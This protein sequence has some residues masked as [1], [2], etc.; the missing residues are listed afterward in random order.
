MKI[1]LKQ[2]AAGILTVFALFGAVWGINEQYTPREVTEMMVA[3]LQKNQMQIQRNIQ[4]QNA[5]QWLF[6]WQMQVN[7]LTGLVAQYP[8]DQ[9]KKNQ[10]NEAKRQRDIWQREVNRLMQR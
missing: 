9:N 10:L 5:Q 6:Y 1:S 7:Q 4:V 8:Y 2:I 3:D